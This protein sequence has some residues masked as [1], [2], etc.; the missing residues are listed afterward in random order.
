M[1]V[2]QSSLSR[3]LSVFRILSLSLSLHL[4]YTRLLLCLSF[5]ASFPFLAQRYIV[6][7]I[8]HLHIGGVNISLSHAPAPP[9]GSEKIMT[10]IPRYGTVAGEVKNEKGYL[11][12]EGVCGEYLN[13]ALRM[14]LRPTLRLLLAPCLIHVLRRIAGARLTPSSVFF[15]TLT[16]PPPHI[17]TPTFYS[18]AH[19]VEWAAHQGRQGPH[20][21]R[22][23]V[24]LCQSRR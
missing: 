7:A 14:V 9:A 15:L 5:F 1:C 6:Y 8:G 19:G 21:W 18:I 22:H 17:H 2:C 20:P 4:L 16:T 10:S 13:P 12:R 23:V 3:D 11:G 24:L